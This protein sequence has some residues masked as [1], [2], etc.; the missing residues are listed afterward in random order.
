[1]MAEAGRHVDRARLERAL[2][3]ASANRL[4]TYDDEGASLIAA[5]RARRREDGAVALREARERL[6]MARAADAS[7]FGGLTARVGAAAGRRG[8]VQMDRVRP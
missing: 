2:G 4:E 7:L 6:M 5:L 3:A 1:M 8:S